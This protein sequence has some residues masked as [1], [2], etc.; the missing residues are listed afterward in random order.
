MYLSIENKL[1]ERRNVYLYIERVWFK[2]LQLMEQISQLTT[3]ITAYQDDIT[4]NVPNNN[5]A[6]RNII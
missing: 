2:K 1:S 4:Q 5:K 3:T 6:T